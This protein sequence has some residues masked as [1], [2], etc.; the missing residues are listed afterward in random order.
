MDQMAVKDKIRCI[1][2]ACSRDALVEML[3]EWYMATD[4]KSTFVRIFLL[5]YLLNHENLL[6]KLERIGVPK[7]IVTLISALLTDRSQRV[8]MGQ[9]TS[10]WEGPNGGIP[11][12]TL[13]GQKVFF[14]SNY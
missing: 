8:K 10:D 13:T 7:H 6:N 9:I 4:S 2:C 5:E 11:Q 1:A 14:S 12:G 3:H